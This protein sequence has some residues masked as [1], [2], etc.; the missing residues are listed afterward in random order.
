MEWNPA[1]EIFYFAGHQLLLSSRRLSGNCFNIECIRFVY[2]QTFQR[3]PPFDLWKWNLGIRWK[4]MMLRAMFSSF[5]SAFYLKISFSSK[6]YR[7]VL[8]R[9]HSFYFI[10][11]TVAIFRSKLKFQKSLYKKRSVCNRNF[12]H[13]PLANYF[14]ASM[15]RGDDENESLPRPA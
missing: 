12:C 13:L 2:S 11:N 8:Y 4:L 9:S 3:L 1:N 10:R 15:K 14:L 7:R 6:G 5:L